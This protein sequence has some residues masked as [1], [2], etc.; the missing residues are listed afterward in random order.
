M[1]LLCLMTSG[2]SLTD[3]MAHLLLRTA[4]DMIRKRARKQNF[5]SAEGEGRLTT[6]FAYALLGC[7]GGTQFEAEVETNLGKGRVRF[8]AKDLTPEQLEL[9]AWVCLPTFA[10]LFGSDETDQEPASENSYGPYGSN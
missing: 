10:E 2:L 6:D 5:K 8:I 4:V 7:S 1:D 9:G 3:E